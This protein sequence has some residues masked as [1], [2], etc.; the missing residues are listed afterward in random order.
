MPV[1]RRFVPTEERKSLRLLPKGV[2]C[3]WVA[4][5]VPLLGMFRGR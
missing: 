5:N 2:V 1:R 3:H 4:G